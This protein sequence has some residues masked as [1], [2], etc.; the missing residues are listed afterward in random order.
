MP[1]DKELER[2]EGESKEEHIA[3]LKKEL[4]ELFEKHIKENEGQ[5]SFAS[6]IE[7][8][9]ERTAWEARQLAQW[10]AR[11]EILQLLVAQG[12]RQRP[13]SEFHGNW[14]LLELRQ[15]W[16]TEDGKAFL[17]AII[18][19]LREEESLWDNTGSKEKQ[20]EMDFANVMPN[21]KRFADFFYVSQM[22]N[23][24]YRD[25]RG[26]SLE[27]AILIGANLEGA[28][29]IGANLQ[30]AILV[31]E[32]LEGAILVRANLQGAHLSR[33]NLQETRLWRANLQGAYLSH[34]NLL[35][36]KLKSA[37]LEGA[38]LTGVNLQRVV[39]VGANLQG[40]VLQNANLEGAVLQNANLRGAI[41]VGANL[42]GAHLKYANLLGAKLS[43]ANLRGA[44]LSAVRLAG[45]VLKKTKPENNEKEQEIHE[46]SVNFAKTVYSREWHGPLW[47]AFL[48]S[49]LTYLLSPITSAAYFVGRGIGKWER[50]WKWLPRA[51]F[52]WE[53]EHVLRNNI[54]NWLKKQDDHKT[55]KLIKRFVNGVRWAKEGRPTTFLGVDTSGLDAS[56]NP[57]LKRDID[58]EQ[59]IADF[60]AKN[61]FAYKLWAWSSDCGRSIALWTF[62]CVAFIVG[63][64]ALY[65]LFPLSKGSEDMNFWKAFYSSVQTFATFGFGKIEPYGVAGEIISTLEV[66]CGYIFFGGLI[67]LF[68]STLTRRA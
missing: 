3:R 48:W 54:L 63:F 41:L 28:I 8:P 14:L 33:A 49:L 66:V 39:F 7:D 56:K 58:D 61:P 35:G 67:A 17:D 4:R 64:A 15:R 65:A 5:P 9:Q 19:G 38:V 25:L 2:K 43:N 22:R 24:E 47:A 40:A 27:G 31:N 59:F 51:K 23:M 44:D 42:Q 55:A 10:N 6:D 13:E 18:V 60:K 11:H 29:L 34:A 21:G 26:A 20:G 36:A 30:G 37:N 16:L 62:W 32:N 50:Q 1:E 46:R 12:E 68:T 57:G 52:A 53:R 45:T